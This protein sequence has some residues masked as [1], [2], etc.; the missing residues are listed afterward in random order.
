MTLPE[1]SNVWPVETVI[2]STT[3]PAAKDSPS[4]ACLLNLMEAVLA[5]AAFFAV[6]FST[7][8]LPSATSSTWSMTMLPAAARTDIEPTSTMAEAMLALSEAWVSEL[9][10]WESG[11]TVMAPSKMLAA[12]YFMVIFILSLYFGVVQQ[13]LAQFVR[14]EGDGLA[15]HDQHVA[16]GQRHHIDHGT[17]GQ[18]QALGCLCAQLDGG[19][20]GI[21]RAFQHDHDAFSHGFHAGDDDLARRHQHRQRTAN[22]YG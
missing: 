16:G 21:G 12:T 17:G 5:L 4:T 10:A 9:A 8:M 2:T 14:D 20:T 7:R 3:V 11:A 1:S 19:A 18:R 6:L 22:H 15:G 13:G